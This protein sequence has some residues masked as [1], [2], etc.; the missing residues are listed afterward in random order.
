MKMLKKRSG[1][2]FLILLLILCMAISAISLTTAQLTG[3]S[4]FA[5]DARSTALQAQEHAQNRADKIRL[6][7]YKDLQP[8]AKKQI[9]N[10]EFYD[11]VSLSPET[12]VPDISRAK[13][14][15]VTIKVFKSSDTVPRIT[16]NLIR[17]SKEKSSVPIGTIIAWASHT[18]P[19]DGTWL[20]C[21]GQST[22]LYPEL[23]AI[24]GA[25]VPDYQGI[26]LRGFGS[27]ASAHYGAVTHSSNALNALQGDAIRNMS[28]TFYANNVSNWGS[29]GVFSQQ[30]TSEKHESIDYKHQSLYYFR[31]S[32][33]AAN[34]VPT[35]NENRPIN[36]AVYWLIKAE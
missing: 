34:G 17:M 7:K 11:E 26:F 28:G 25:N 35:A 10:T 14:R 30:R 6:T 36:R 33:N 12:D 19:D 31:Y 27:Q 23:A 3:S 21:N 29:S 20:I 4:Y 18:M 32:F 8:Q 9:P 22:A 5:L 2:G 1:S 16:L 15:T 24:V 13:Q